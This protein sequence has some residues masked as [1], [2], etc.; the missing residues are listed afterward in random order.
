M[1]FADLLS[2]HLL[3]FLILVR[4]MVDAGRILIYA[5]L[6]ATLQDCMVSIHHALNWF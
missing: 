1:L 3:M 5:R 6:D 2:L 4:F